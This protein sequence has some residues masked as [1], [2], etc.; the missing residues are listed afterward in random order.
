MVGGIL[1][2]ALIVTSARRLGLVAVRLDEVEVSDPGPEAVALRLE[3][4]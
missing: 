1:P 2:S 4:T 3:Q